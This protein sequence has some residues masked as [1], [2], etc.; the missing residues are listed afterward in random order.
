MPEKMRDRTVRIIK[1]DSKKPETINFEKVY[2]VSRSLIQ[3]NNA[4][5]A[6]RHF[7]K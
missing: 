2:K 4:M 7:T 5:K 1:L 6:F 3:T